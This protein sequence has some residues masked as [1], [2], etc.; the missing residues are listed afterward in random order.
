VLQNK[1]QFAMRGDQ[2]RG[3]NFVRAAVVYVG[4]GVHAP[5][6]GYSDYEG[7]DVEGK[8][9][10]M[11][12]NAPSTL[13]ADH[14]AYYSSRRVKNQE[15]VARGAIGVIALRSQRSVESFPWERVKQVV[16][17]K[18]SMT[19][20]DISGA[21][22]GY[23]PEIAGAAYISVDTAT[24]MMAGTPISFEGARAATESDTPASVP[25]GI[26]VTLAR[27]TTHERIE[28]PNVIGVVRG[29]DP[30]LADEY[31]V[32]SAHLDHT[33]IGEPVAGSTDKINNGAYDNA[34]GIALMIE[35]ARAIAAAPPR[36]SV[37]FIGLTAEEKGLLGS[38]YFAHYPTVPSAAIVANVN[39]DMPL[40]LFPVSEIIGYGAEHSSLKAPMSAAAEAEGFVLVPDPLP[41]ENFFVRSDQYSF[42]KKGI[43]ASYLDVSF[44]SSD[45]DLDG[46]ALYK[47]HLKNH[48][49]KP[50]DDLSRPVDWD[51]AVR[52][53]RA[54]AR[55]GLAI[56]NDDERPAWNE[57]DFFGEMFAP[58]D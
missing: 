10:A 48:Y 43:P 44:T 28:S 49:H 58:E 47:D 32:F 52:F 9:V 23:F 18:P 6:F 51:S 41:E 29:T 25:L 33:G 35:A 30:E 16:G 38:D 4:F 39:L 55:I 15:I 54:N 8:I 37:M 27:K 3:E 53:A 22:S 5:D 12:D 40:F 24:Q 17:K 26:E 1:E 11:F 46:E 21:A 34:M 50:S 20:V 13:P 14:R 31:V 19:W 42:V 56:A 45:P 57:G 7:I 36:R 2:V